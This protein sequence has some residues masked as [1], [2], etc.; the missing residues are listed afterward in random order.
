METEREFFLREESVPQVSRESG[1][2]PGQD[3]EKMGFEYPDRPFRC[4]AAMG[5]GQ[6]EL[7]PGLPGLSDILLVVCT[8]LIV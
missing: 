7:V 2:Y 6:D 8:E 1:I 5:M 4:I 3:R